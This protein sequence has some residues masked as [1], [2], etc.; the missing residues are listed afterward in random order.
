M[1]RTL[2]TTLLLVFALGA[3]SAPGQAA[4]GAPVLHGASQ[5]K[6]HQDTP[7]KTVL[8]LS[9]LQR[10][11]SHQG[12]DGEPLSPSYGL[13][14]EARVL[15]AERFQ[16]GYRQRRPAAC[17]WS[18]NIADSPGRLFGGHDTHLLALFA[19]WRG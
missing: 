11:F 12:L 19:A 15:P 7:G 3:F 8:N 2:F 9:R 13:A 16:R 1:L 6:A 5:A 17:D 18:L 10:H 14:A 4:Q